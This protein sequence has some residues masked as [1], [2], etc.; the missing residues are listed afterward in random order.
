MVLVCI[1]GQTVVSTKE[2]GSRT[3]CTDME[4]STGLMEGCTKG[5]TSMIER[6][7][8]GSLNGQM[9]EST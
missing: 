6:K 2:S 1:N 4:S 8:T 5:V 7:V 3:R 9:D